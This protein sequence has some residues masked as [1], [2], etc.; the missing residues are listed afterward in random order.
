MSYQF[1]Y[2]N[3]YIPIGKRDIVT[4]SVKETKLLVQHTSTICI[5]NSVSPSSLKMR[6][7]LVAKIM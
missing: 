6:S 5:W 1:K 4:G 3:V 7:V 2:D